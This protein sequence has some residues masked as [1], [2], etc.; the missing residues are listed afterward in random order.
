MDRD[1][2]RRGINL[3]ARQRWVIACFSCERIHTKRVF[4]YATHSVFQA[5]YS[6]V[7]QAVTLKLDL[8]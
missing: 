1:L 8:F 3:V 5:M 2:D 7:H 6:H 4:S